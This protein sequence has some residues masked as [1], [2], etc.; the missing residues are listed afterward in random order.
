[1]MMYQPKPRRKGKPRQQ[2]R[3]Q[4]H[5]EE[6][7]THITTNRRTTANEL[8]L[9]PVEDVLAPAEAPDGLSFKRLKKQLE[10]HKKCWEESQSWQT[11]RRAMENGTAADASRIIDNCVCV[12]LGS[13]S[14]FIR[15]GLVDRRAVSLYQ[16]AALAT[17][18]EYFAHEDTPLEPIKACYAQDPVFNKLDRQLLESIG[19]SVVEDPE[20]FALINERTFLYSPGAERTHLL[21]MLPSNPALFFGGPLDGETLARLPDD[22]EDPLTKFTDTRRSILLPSFE[23]NIP[24]FWKTS[25]FWRHENT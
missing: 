18:L 20:A 24:A 21:D 5:D 14:G 19:V 11:M 13:P 25:L 3:I 23:P 7:W 12:G 10:W 15:G 6:G 9:P 4:V 16:L 1:M 2:K 22:G 8:R 17:V